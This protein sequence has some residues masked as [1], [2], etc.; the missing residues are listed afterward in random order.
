MPKTKR[1]TTP[2]DGAK[3]RLRIREV[4][5]YAVYAMLTAEEQMPNNPAF[6]KLNDVTGQTPLYYIN[7]ERRR[8]WEQDGAVLSIRGGSALRLKRN[9]PPSTQCSEAMGPDIVEGY[10]NGKDYAKSCMEAWRVPTFAEREAA[11]AGHQEL[12]EA[13]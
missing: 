8:Q 12:R 6:R 10:L 1:T 11:R 5:T 3:T 2:G 7:D 13:A 9:L 4:R